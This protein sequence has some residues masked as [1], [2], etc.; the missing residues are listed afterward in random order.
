MEKRLQLSALR[1][2]VLVMVGV[3]GANW[4]FGAPD[5][6]FDHFGISKK[7]LY[8]VLIGIAVFQA[9]SIVVL[10]DTIKNLLNNHAVWKNKWAKSAPVVIAGFISLA[11]STSV[12][13][14]STKEVSFGAVSD[15]EL[16]LLLIANGVLLVVYACL[17]GFVR[18]LLL[19]LRGKENAV[20]A[21][22]PKVLSLW[23]KKLADVVPIEHEK[24]V[25]LDHNYDG[26]MELDNN[27]PPWWK[28]MFYASIVFGFAYLGHYHLLKTGLSSAEE[29]EQE[30]EIAEAAVAEYLKQS[31]ANVDETSVKMVDDPGRL[32]KGG[33]IFKMSCAACHGQKGEGGV[34]PNFTDKYWLHGGSIKDIFK[35]IKYG[36]P[37]K[38]MISWK[39]QL[40]PVQIQD[41]ASFIITLQGTNPP[42]AK[43]PQGDLFEPEE[44]E[45]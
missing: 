1:R 16:W 45:G 32:A 18:N 21:K 26:I 3:F 15:E 14:A 23:A 19:D 5:S 7:A 38:G 10:L 33:E 39:A 43:E 34:G 37:E 28:L 36:V 24:D 25:L 13:A 4:C 42:N 6:I 30:M 29:Y 31:A 22:A 35:T 12:M 27:L 2:T 40:S 44:V 20:T 11:M 9:I 8:Y 17:V 41:V